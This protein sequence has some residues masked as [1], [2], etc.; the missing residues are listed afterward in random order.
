MAPEV[1]KQ[2]GV[3]TL[4]D[5]WSVGC[6]LIYMISGSAPWSYLGP[7]E[8]VFKQLTNMVV[9]PH[10]LGITVACE[11]F[12]D[13]CLQIIPTQRSSVA[14]LLSH[15]FITGIPSSP[16]SKISKESIDLK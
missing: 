1:V 15:P 4:S 9:P 12:L 7:E 8:E 5:V 6:L 13:S 2:L 3:S 11:N 14:E 10:P 16:K